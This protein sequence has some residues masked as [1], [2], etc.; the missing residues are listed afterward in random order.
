MTNVSISPSNM[1]SHTAVR[2]WAGNS[3]VMDWLAGSHTRS[4]VKGSC[5]GAMVGTFASICVGSSIGA[6]TGTPS[7]GGSGCRSVTQ[8]GG[9]LF[10][11][12]AFWGM[13]FPDT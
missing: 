2:L 6:G 1:H 11:G 4:D 13:C 3:C 7:V 9:G 12:V 5:S 10:S 8:G